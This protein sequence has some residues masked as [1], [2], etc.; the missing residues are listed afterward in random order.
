MTE[1][2]WDREWRH[3][4]RGDGRYPENHL[5]EAVYGYLDL[6]DAANSAPN[7]GQAP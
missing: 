4:N 1:T 2:Y 3:D 7:A 5:W 6:L